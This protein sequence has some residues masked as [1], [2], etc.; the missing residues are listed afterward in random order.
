LVVTNGE[1]D[2]YKLQTLIFSLVV[3]VAL[4]SAGEE[5]LASFAV[6]QTLL[7]IL[8]LSQIVYVAGKL[9]APAS[10][11]DLDDAI[12]RLRQLQDKLQM[13]VA[14]NTDTDA[15]GKLISPPPQ[16]PVASAPNATRQY[17]KQADQVEVML[18]S[19]LGVVVNRATLNP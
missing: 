5:R 8:G 1:F 11:A 14:Q 9:A 15:D 7:G 16:P 17:D 4:L 13:A 10:I 12:T 18:E 2:V 6:P 19:T 3:G